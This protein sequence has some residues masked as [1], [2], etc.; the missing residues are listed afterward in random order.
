MQGT[1]IIR[2]GN[3][4]KKKKRKH[5]LPSS[6]ESPAFGRIVEDFPFAFGIR[7][8]FSSS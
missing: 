7:M 4:K 3:E 6:K 2:R 8:K 1:I 5:N